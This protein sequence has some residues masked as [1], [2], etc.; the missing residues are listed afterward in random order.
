MDNISIYFLIVLISIIVS[1]ISI[2]YAINLRNY[3]QEF[4]AVS[5]NK[6]QRIPCKNKHISKR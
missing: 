6:Q 4:I 5:K 2:R 3:L 1:I